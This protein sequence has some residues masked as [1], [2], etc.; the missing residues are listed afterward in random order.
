M[1]QNGTFIGSLAITQKQRRATFVNLTFAG[2][3]AEFFHQNVSS[4]YVLS[5]WLLNLQK[6][7]TLNIGSIFADSQELLRSFWKDL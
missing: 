3:A 1:G 7:C 4:L 2:F 5:I 6:L